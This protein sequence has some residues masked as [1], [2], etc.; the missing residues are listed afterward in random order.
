MATGFT[1]VELLV[2]LV[3]LALIT[4]IMSQAMAQ[5]LRIDGLLAT[6]AMPAQ[7]MA[8]RVEWIRQ[9]LAALQPPDA[10][11][12]SAFSGT[13]RRLVGSSGNPLASS[14]AG[15]GRV[16]L[17]LLFDPGS[18]ETALQAVLSDRTDPIAILRWRRDRGAF[19]YYDSKGNRSDSWPPPLAMPQALPTTIV[20]ETGLDAP[21]V[22]VGTP[23]ITNDENPSR[24][25]IE[26]M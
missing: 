12:H 15:F 16:D 20:L 4:T 22:I 10:S 11:G 8:V 2:T 24:L 17:T 1:L 3:V 13:Q 9:A 5:F 19:S 7:A 23:L 26:Q 21:T 14:P 6:R 18:G 25:Q